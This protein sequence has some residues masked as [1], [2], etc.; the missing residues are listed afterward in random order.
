MFSLSHN[1]SYIDIVIFDNKRLRV[2][3]AFCGVFVLTTKSNI[4][5]RIR[6]IPFPDISPEIFSI[7]FFGINL[8]LRWY[9]VSYI[10]GFICALKLMKFFIVRE[11]LWASN[12]PPFSTDQADTFLTYLILGVII[13]GRLGYVFFYNLEY[14]AL[15]PIAIFR[16]WDGGMA[17]HGGFIGVIIAVILFSLSNKLILWSTADLIAVSTPPGLL[18]GR[19]ANFINNELWGRPTEVYWGVIFPGE[20]AQ[21]CDGVIGPCARHP[22]QLYEAVLEG[23]LLLI[24]LLFIAFKGGLKRPGLLTGVFALGYGTSRFFVE[25]FRVPDPQF[26]SPANPYGFAYKLGDLGMTMGQIL[27]LP[28]ILVGL[29]LCIRCAGYKENTQS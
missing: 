23:L 18:F 15:N 9:A 11:R 7:E 17:F 1:S 13:G 26:F 29:Y 27:S 6:M 19:V 4:S 22:S 12:N 3:L 16:I 14:Y 8:A 25:Y 21:K 10:L 2:T 20:L 5:S 28:M 24:V